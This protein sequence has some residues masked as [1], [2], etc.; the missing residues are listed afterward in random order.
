MYGQS[1]ITLILTIDISSGVVVLYLI[2]RMTVSVVTLSLRTYV[3][4]E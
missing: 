4:A 1:H 3:C 2:I